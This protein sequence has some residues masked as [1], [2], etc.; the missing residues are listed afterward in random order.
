MF[1]FDFY[2]SIINLIYIYIYIYIYINFSFES[3]VN[4]LVILYINAGSADS[5][6]SIAVANWLVVLLMKKWFSTISA[7]F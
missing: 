1:I 5:E 6:I 4:W 2:K 3:K 7:K